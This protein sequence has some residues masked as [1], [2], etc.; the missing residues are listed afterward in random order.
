[1][2]DLNQPYVLSKKDRKRRAK[3]GEKSF[4]WGGGLL[5]SNKDLQ[6]YAKKCNSKSMLDCE[7]DISSRDESRL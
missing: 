4:N 3:Y 5:K 6:R 7:K 1:V 2:K